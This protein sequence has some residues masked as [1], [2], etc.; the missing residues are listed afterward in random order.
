MPQFP[1][2]HPRPGTDEQITR[3]RSVALSVFQASSAIFYW[4][5]DGRSMVVADTTGP[6]CRYIGRYLRDMQAFDP[7]N[8]ERLVSSRKRVATMSYDR[9]LA[10]RSA[11]ERYSSYLTES[12]IA[13]VL[14]FVF[15]HDDEPI[16]GL[17]ILKHRDDPPISGETLRVAQSMQ[18]YIE[19][20]IGGH[21]RQR[22]GRR[23]RQMRLVHGLT[24]REIEI[25]E[26][27]RDGLANRHIAE[28]LDI[29]LGTVKT[30]LLHIFQKMD[31]SSRTMLS[32]R[33]ADID[34]AAAETTA[35]LA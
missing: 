10:P 17:G 6:G 13:D 27:I 9:S 24:T 30:H 2:F 25:A 22:A 15:W 26:L 5:D 32:I 21:P 31:V 34:A 12:D 7:L 3:I 8:I 11:F 16:A 19:Y 29:G 18:P 35:T 23:H 33:L 28:A 4:I 14:D 1:E 20:H